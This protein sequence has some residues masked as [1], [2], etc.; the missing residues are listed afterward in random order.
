M[1]LGERLIII[2]QFNNP[3]HPVD[4]LITSLK[5]STFSLNL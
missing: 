1:D 4:V 5:A 2:E 3:S